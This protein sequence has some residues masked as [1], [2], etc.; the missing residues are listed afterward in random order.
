[1]SVCVVGVVVICHLERQVMTEAFLCV[2]SSTRTQAEGNIEGE[3]YGIF[4]VTHC[5]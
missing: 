5:S 2:F 1:M 4:L 3:M